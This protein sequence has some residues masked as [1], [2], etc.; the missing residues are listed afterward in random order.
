MHS[1]KG[2]RSNLEIKGQGHQAKA[3]YTVYVVTEERMIVITALSLMTTH[4]E[5]V[6]SYTRSKVKVT[7]LSTL[8]IYPANGTVWLTARSLENFRLV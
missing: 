4:T 1:W 6:H 3:H 2:Q 8:P 7:W 5:N